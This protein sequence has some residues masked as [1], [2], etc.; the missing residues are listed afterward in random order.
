[1]GSALETLCGQAY[2]AG[3]LDMMGIYMQSAWVILITTALLV[4]HNE[5]MLGL[6]WS[7]FGAQWLMVVHSVGSVGLYF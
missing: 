7:C 1:M 5:T 4:V 2:G 3:R 6:S